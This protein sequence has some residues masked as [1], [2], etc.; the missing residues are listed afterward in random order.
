MQKRDKTDL[1]KVKK[2]T[3]GSKQESENK[4][5]KIKEKKEQSFRERES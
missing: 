5:Q 3:F 1:V 4:T 2:K